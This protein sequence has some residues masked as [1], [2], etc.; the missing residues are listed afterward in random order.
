MKVLSTII[1]VFVF[2]I[3]C[4][5][6]TR[7]TE[8]Q[9]KEFAEKCSKTDT[10]N[11]LNFSLTGFSYAEIQ[12]VVI[13]QIHSGQIIDSFFVHPDKNSLDSLRTRY[14]AYTDRPLYIKDTFQ[15]I[16]QG[17]DPFVLSDMKMIMWE[18]FSMSSESYGCVMGD[19][20]INGIRFEHN[21][22]PDFIKKGFKFS[23]GK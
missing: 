20:K 10:A 14:S 17:H 21:A 16:I 15:V 2:I 18:Q 7:W 12:N 9:K 23:W 11:G 8:K 6:H 19:Y 3:G 1:F 22:N 4:T 13:R 5:T